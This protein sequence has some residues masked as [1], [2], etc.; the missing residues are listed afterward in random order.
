MKTAN[1]FVV[2][3]GSMLLHLEPAEEGGYLVTSPYD[4][5]LL[6]QAEDIQEAFENAADALK[7]LEETRTPTKQTKRKKPIPNS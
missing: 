5:E 3:N 4:A 2:S 7:L 1:I 6:T